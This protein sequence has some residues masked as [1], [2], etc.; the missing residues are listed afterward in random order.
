MDK[1]QKCVI[2]LQLTHTRGACYS[3]PPRLLTD[4]FCT[5]ADL[6]R[7]LHLQ[8]R[9]TMRRV[10]PSG[11]IAAQNVHVWHRLCDVRLFVTTPTQTYTQ[12]GFRGEKEQK[13]EEKSMKSANI[14]SFFSTPSRPSAPHQRGWAAPPWPAGCEE[15]LLKRFTVLDPDSRDVICFCIQAVAQKIFH[16]SLH[17]IVW[18]GLPQPGGGW[19]G[20]RGSVIR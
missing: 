18:A 9:R 6:L 10:T 20:W 14:S 12:A 19:G 17:V 4:H 7:S 13:Q 2:G 5:N 11:R 3:F 16:N 15:Q 8:A 1:F